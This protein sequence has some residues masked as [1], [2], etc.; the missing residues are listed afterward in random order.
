MNPVFGQLAANIHTQ[1][2]SLLGRGGSPSGGGML[3]PKQVSLLEKSMSVLSESK[4]NEYDGDAIAATAA[5]RERNFFKEISRNPQL[6]DQHPLMHLISAQQKLLMTT[7]QSGIVMSK[8]AAKAE[9]IYQKGYGRQSTDKS[10]PLSSYKEELPYLI[11]GA[12]ILPSKL[13]HMREL[14]KQK[15]KEDRLAAAQRQALLQTLAGGSGGGGG[16][17][18]ASAGGASGTGGTKASSDSH[19]AFLH[20]ALQNIEEEIGNAH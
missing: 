19:R 9:G 18:Y 20:G 5:E 7:Q 2:H 11:R 6:R 16:G 4:M 3:S 15:K 13:K 17:G 1:S 12:H 8:A 14:E 10:A